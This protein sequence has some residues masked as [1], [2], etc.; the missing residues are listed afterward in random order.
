M[1]HIYHLLTIFILIGC[2]SN[3]IIDDRVE[4]QLSFNNPIEELAVTKTHQLTT[5]YTNNVGEVLT[6]TISWS[7]SE[8]SILTVS[9]N[10]LLTA[11][12]LGTTDIIA[13]T[14]TSEGET[15]RS[16]LT[17][18]VISLEETLTINNSIEN[19]IVN[20]EHQYQTTFVNA[21]G[22]IE[23]VSITWSS[24]DSNIASV[25]STGLVTA[26]NLGDVVITASTV[27][28]GKT[29]STEDGFTVNPVGE[30]M[31]IN[32]PIEELTVGDTH[33][34][35][36]TYT[37]NVGQNENITI[38]WSSSNDSIASVDEQ[39]TVT[40]KTA[41]EVTIKASYTNTNGQEISDTDTFNIQAGQTNTKSGT[42]RTTSS[43]ELTGAFTLSEIPGTNDLELKINDDYRASTALPG[44]YL[45]MTN[46]PNTVGNAKEIQKVA[47]F[48]GSHTYIIPNTGINDFSHL[49]YWCKPFSVK[50][51]DGE[52]TE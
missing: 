14:E 28:D 25:S 30:M 18:T 39:G 10:G 40:A 45:Y 11:I 4:E 1:K 41:G 20:N 47:V 17:I 36:A 7:S 16:S 33:Q 35:T 44:L 34:Y 15:I 22:I 48:S 38:N 12:S 43:Y 19:I 49:L 5:K 13:N 9:E 37:N 21:L 29:I 24:S 26:N 8:N 23:N 2:V 31:S 46:N 6:P 42:I 52:I 51:G 50:V 3:D 32:N 27:A